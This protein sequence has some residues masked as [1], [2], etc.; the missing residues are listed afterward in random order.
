MKSRYDSADRTAACW[1]VV[2]FEPGAGWVATGAGWVVAT[3]AGSV[4]TGA[5]WVATGA[6]WVVATGA[7]CVATEVEGSMSDIA[8]VDTVVPPVST[9]SSSDGAAIA[10]ITIS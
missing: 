6:G 2:R 5:G 4:A 10:P 8:C 9:W 3:G 1:E 7:G